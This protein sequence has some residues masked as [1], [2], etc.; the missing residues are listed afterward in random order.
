MLKCVV[1]PG[2]VQDVLQAAA[3]KAR[4]V[5]MEISGVCELCVS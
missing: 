3:V 4:H 5:N 2:S 1:G